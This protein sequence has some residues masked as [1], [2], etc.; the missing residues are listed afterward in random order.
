[1]QSTIGQVKTQASLPMLLILE[2]VLF[3]FRRRGGAAARWGCPAATS[4][5]FPLEPFDAQALLRLLHAVFA[6]P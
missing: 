3:F 4:P 1:M 2:E 6:A 5:A